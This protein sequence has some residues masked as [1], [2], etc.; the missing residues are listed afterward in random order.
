MGGGL[1][2]VDEHLAALRRGKAALED[3]VTGTG[4]P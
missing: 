2:S 3:L 4:R 1:R